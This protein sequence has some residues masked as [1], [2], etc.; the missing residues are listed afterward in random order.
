MV[1]IKASASTGSREDQGFLSVHLICVLFLLIPWKPCTLEMWKALDLNSAKMQNAKWRW[2]PSVVRFCY[3]VVSSI[4]S[5]F[6]SLC[7]LS[8]SKIEQ[9]VNIMTVYFCCWFPTYVY[10]CGSY[11]ETSEKRQNVSLV[12]EYNSC[13][14]RR[15]RTDL[16]GYITSGTVLLCFLLFLWFPVWTLILRVKVQPNNLSVFIHSLLHALTFLCTSPSP[17]G[18]TFPGSKQ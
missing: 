10:F 6:F 2:G 4:F 3:S 11:Q 15:Q 12:S 13:L 9:Q 17:A 16:V 8:R 14:L 7:I 1:H 18:C 5:I